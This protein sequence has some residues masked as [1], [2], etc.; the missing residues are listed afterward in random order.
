[1][2]LLTTV[3][4]VLTDEQTE[5]QIAALPTTALAA[6]A[7]ARCLLEIHPWSGDPIQKDNPNGPVRILPR[8]RRMTSAHPPRY[9]SCIPK[10]KREAFGMLVR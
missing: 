7:E 9:S 3:Y 10:S 8:R 4:A 5:Q 6:L 2:L 1:M